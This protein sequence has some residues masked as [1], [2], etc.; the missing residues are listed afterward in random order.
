MKP[1]EYRQIMKS[2]ETH[3]EEFKVSSLGSQLFVDEDKRTMENQFNK[4]QT[5]YDQ[6]VVQLPVHSQYYTK[7]TVMFRTQNNS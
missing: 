1:E 3:F 5:H 6:L 7:Y 4:A 2:L